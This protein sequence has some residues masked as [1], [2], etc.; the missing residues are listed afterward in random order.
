MGH[1]Q[2]RSEH[3]GEHG[4]VVGLLLDGWNQFAVGSALETHRRKLCAE[5]EVGI[6]LAAVGAEL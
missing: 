5:E 6:G 2:V 4:S 1:S 3:S